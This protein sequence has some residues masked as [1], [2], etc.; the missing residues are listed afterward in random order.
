MNTESAKDP[1]L[2]ALVDTL[3]ARLGPG[4]FQ[5]VD[6]WPDDPM[7]VGIASPYDA[8]YLAYIS[9][10]PGVDETYFVSLEFPPKGDWADH[11]YTPGGERNECAIDELV[12]TISAHLRA[13]QPNTSLERTRER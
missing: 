9:V 1:H 8:G 13:A 10:T 6:Y 4:A 12:T 7:A 3:R 5:I 11:P 2:V